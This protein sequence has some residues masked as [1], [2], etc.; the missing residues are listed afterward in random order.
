LSVK[1]THT[2]TESSGEHEERNRSKA[3]EIAGYSLGD[4]RN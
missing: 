4:S 1:K 2:L 3:G